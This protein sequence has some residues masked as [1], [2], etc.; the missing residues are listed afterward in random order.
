[1]NATETWGRAAR[2]AVAAGLALVS[3]A[4]GPGTAAGKSVSEGALVTTLGTDTLSVERFERRDDRVTGRIVRRTPRTSVV[5]YDVAVGKNGRPERATFRV[6]PPAGVTGGPAPRTVRVTLRPDSAFSEEMRDT[7]V[8]RAWALGGGDLG[9]QD[10]YGLAELW[11]ARLMAGKADTATITLVAPLGGIS[12]RWPVRRGGGDSAYFELP[13]GPFR[14]RADRRGRLLALDGSLSPVK[15]LVTRERTL[16]LDG[17]AAAWA[18]ADRRGKGL[19]STSPR[20]TAHAAFGACSLWVDYGR[21]SKRGRKVFERGVLGDT[22]WRTGANAA[23]Q[24]A[25]QCAVAI[26]GNALPAGRY[27]LWTRVRGDRYFLL[28]NSQTGQW[29]TVHDPARDL[30]EVPLEKRPLDEAVERFTIRLEPG[31]GGGTLLLQWDDAELVVPV[32]ARP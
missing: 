15:H 29:G 6:A 4:S 30:F 9:M 3:A 28:V 25:T 8:R 31:P 23:T 16:D 19:G 32:E 10:S 7:V 12:G 17:L 27:T 14:I 1:M 21:P 22:L 13:N 18:E 11:L 5:D 2:L 26:G 20:D 24:L